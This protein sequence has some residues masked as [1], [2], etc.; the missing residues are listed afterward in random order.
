MSARFGPGSITSSG[1]ATT[2]TTKVVYVEGTSQGISWKGDY[3]GSTQYIPNDIVRYNNCT[4]ICIQSSSGNL[5][6]NILLGIQHF[7]EK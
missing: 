1:T 4:F 7:S 3:V 2:S 6:S 5:P